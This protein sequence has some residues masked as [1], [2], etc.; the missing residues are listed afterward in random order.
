MNFFRIDRLINQSIKAF[1]LDLTG[2]RVLTEAASGFFAL[3]PIIAAVAGADFV[4]TITKNS[5]YGRASDILKNLNDLA[6]IWEVH[7]KIFNLPSKNHNYISKADIITNL[8]HVRPLTKSFLERLKP[9]AVIPLMWETWEYR[10]AD[11]DLRECNRLGI[12]VLG[13]NENH[14]NLKTFDYVGIL[15]L[16][17][18]LDLELEICNSYILLIGNSLFANI[19]NKYLIMNGSNCI[20]FPDINQFNNHQLKSNLINIDAIIV[21]DQS[22]EEIIGY[23]SLLLPETI[24]QLNPGIAVV[25]ICGN[26]DSD[27]IINSK[28]SLYPKFIAPTGYMSLSTEYLGPKPLIDLHTAG[29]KVG[30][31]L[32]KARLRGLCKNEA[33][34]L[35]LEKSPAMDFSISQKVLYDFF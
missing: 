16:K 14:P 8:G 12:P 13:T 26:I 23:K 15:A 29:L 28:I 1:Q 30:E 10:P 32:A 19:I 25:H 33:I 27:A 5:R 7:D 34:K 35:A 2:L 11:L 3:T 31:V 20:F 22:N 24:N 6:V 21:A 17:I 18:L 4:Y 9:T